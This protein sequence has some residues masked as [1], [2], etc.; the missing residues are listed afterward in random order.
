[1]PQQ[2]ISHQTE[3]MRVLVTGG[4]GFIGT[5]LMA[6]YMAQGINVLNLDKDKPRDS[7]HQKKWREVDVL[8][9][10][11]LCQEIYTFSP[12][13]IIHLAARTDL[14]EKRNL[15]G[16]A[17]NT[18]G[19]S[20]LIF[21]LKDL[22]DLQR[23]IFA[24][25]LLV[26]RNG[27]LPKK[28]TEYC[29][30]TL[31]GQSKAIGEKLVRESKQ[32]PCSWVII[33]PTSV[34]GPWFGVPYRNYFLQIA[35]D[36]YFHL[37]KTKT[38]KTFGFVGN[39]IVQIAKLM[40][41]PIEEVNQKIFYLADYQPYDV[42]E[43]SNLIQKEIKSKK[44]KALPMGIIRM[45]AI[46]GDLAKV[47]GWTNPPITSFRLKNMLT[48]NFVYDLNPIKKI[49]P[50]LPFSTELGVHATVEWLKK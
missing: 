41:A 10:E 49:I 3:N 44:I 38:L 11:M 42:R 31:Y 39:V 26:C 17:A 47:F 27:Y 43:W 46:V 21:S 18:T 22:P 34:W 23:V 15:S 32:I 48:N 8:D 16:Y 40:E 1:M 36:Q 20:N 2:N 50:D 35:K 25:S 24:S 14:N 28:D 33:R 12:T 30:D 45:M 5:N 7:G 29:P 4:S 37:G 6:H 19:V 9:R 13:H